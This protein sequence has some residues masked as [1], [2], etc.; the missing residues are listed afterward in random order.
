MLMPDAPRFLR[1][2][3][4]PFGRRPIVIEQAGLDYL[5]RFAAR[6]NG[7]KPST[8]PFPFASHRTLAQAATQNGGAA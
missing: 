8:E 6:E 7:P 3:A 2:G 1:P 5:A 4:R